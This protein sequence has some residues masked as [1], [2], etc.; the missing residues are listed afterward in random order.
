MTGEDK[1]RRMADVA[2][3]LANAREVIMRSVP[4]GV[5]R[6]LVLSFMRVV[7]ARALEAIWRAR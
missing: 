1:R 2:A 7:R 6:K 4:H 5:G 3:A